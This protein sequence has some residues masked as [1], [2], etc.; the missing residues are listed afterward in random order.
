MEVAAPSAAVV[1]QVVIKEAEEIGDGLMMKIGLAP[2]EL[3][4]P[5]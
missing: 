1:Y 4:V 3:N 2:K 5:N